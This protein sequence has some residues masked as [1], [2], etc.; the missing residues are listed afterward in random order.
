MARE[1]GTDPGCR[2]R[3]HNGKVQNRRRTL[4]PPSL[5]TTL[6]AIAPTAS[7]SDLIP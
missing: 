4:E 2:I 1:I 3:S 5:F 7:E 6:F